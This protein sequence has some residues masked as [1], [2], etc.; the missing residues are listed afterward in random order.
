M[1][2]QHLPGPATDQ[3]LQQWFR[4]L[5]LS[6]SSWG[7]A[8]H[9]RYSAHRHGYDKFL[10]CVRGSIVFVLVSGERVSLIAGDRMFLPAGTE[11]AAI[12]GDHGV[13][14]L[15]APSPAGSLTLPAVD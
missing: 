7:N 15:E 13:Q 9:D 14:C 11:H 1:A 5:G 12:V 2:V 4:D 10:A 3:E 8:P 6:P